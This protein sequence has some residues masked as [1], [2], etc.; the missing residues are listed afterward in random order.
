VVVERTLEGLKVAR[1]EG[2]EDALVFFI[3]QGAVIDELSP[4]ITV[5]GPG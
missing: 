3:A 2:V 1:F 5:A 4:V